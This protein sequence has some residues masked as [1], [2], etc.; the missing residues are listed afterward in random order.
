MPESPSDQP[1][2]PTPAILARITENFIAHPVGEG[3]IGSANGRPGR[4]VQLEGAWFY[5]QRR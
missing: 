3:V 1:E 4:F 5:I 2:P